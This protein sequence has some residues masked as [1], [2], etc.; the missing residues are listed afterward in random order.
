MR[1]FNKRS[2]F[3]SSLL[4]C[5]VTACGSPGHRGGAQESEPPTPIE[6]TPSTELPG[7][8]EPEP[9]GTQTPAAEVPATPVPDEDTGPPAPAQQPGGSTTAE[10]PVTAPTYKRVWVVSTTG[11]DTASG[12]E[13]APLRTISRAITLAGPGEL[14]RVR[15]GTYTERLLISG[16]VRSGTAD[17]PITLQGEGNPRII[18]GSVTGALMVVEKPYWL[19][20]GFNFDIQNRK[21]LGVAFTG[22]LQGTKLSNSE[23]HHGQYGA[24][25]SFHFSANGA[26]LENNHIH[27]I[28]ITGKDAHGVIIQPTARNITLRGNVIHDNSGDSIQCYSEDGSS[29]AAP[30]DG[31]LIEGNDLYGNIEQS[32]D[33]KTCYNVTVR[34]NK[35]HL[36]RRHP[37]LGGNGTMVVHMSAKNV[38]IEDNDFYDAG[39]AIGVGGNRVGPYPSGIVIRRNRIRD[40]LTL[41]GM[42][43]GGLQLAVSTGTKVYNNTFTRLQG[44]ALT[45]GMGDGGPTENLVVKNNIIDAAYVM[46]MGGQAPGLKMGSNL[47]RPGAT[48]NGS[49][50]SQ[51]K[52]R[53]FDANSF[54]SST[55]LNST[56]LAPA[57]AAIDR[58]ENVGLPFCGSAPDIGAVESGC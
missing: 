9:G 58:G 5:L 37:T 27:H 34:R 56:T 53:G 29:S 40:M 45:V 10:S 2:A 24:G 15:S 50:L 38:L 44:P 51:W 19:I 8:T 17:A 54:E 55:L 30:A 18:L 36:A 13:T 16:A 52:A 12:S 46:K 1:T 47:Y 6:V 3:F 4:A 39:L 26:T 31:V 7:T 28:F 49:T 57:S 41:G 21:A 20:S 35:M 48:F 32:L 22:N 43:G 23:I 42:T 11:S 33:I 25:V 14:I